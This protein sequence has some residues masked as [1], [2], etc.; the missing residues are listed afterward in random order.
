M[1]LG[2]GVEGGEGTT[3]TR[4]GHEAEMP[5]RLQDLNARN[6]I[7]PFSILLTIFTEMGGDGDG[8]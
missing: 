6:H 5:G 4:T 3:S 7:E 1:S 8:S 2:L